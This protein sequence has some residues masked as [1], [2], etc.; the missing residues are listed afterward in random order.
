MFNQTIVIGN[1]GNAPELRYTQTGKAVCSFSV[2]HNES[3]TGQNGQ[4]VETVT[5]FRVTAWEKLAE[6]CNQYLAKG[7]LVQV[8]GKVKASAYLNKNGEAMASLELTADKVT[9]LNSGAN[10]AENG[11]GE[12]PQSPQR[13]TAQPASQRVRVEEPTSA[14]IFND[15]EIPF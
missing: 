4:L 8:V 5:W 12:R 7:S 13:Q 9:F 15:E 10:K 11:G 1:L 14:P 3:Y 6:I 2:A